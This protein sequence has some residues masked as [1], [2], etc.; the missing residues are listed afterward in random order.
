[1]RQ[2]ELR[3]TEK[4]PEGKIKA[5]IF[6]FDGTFSTLRCGWE[7]VMRPLMLEQISGGKAEDASEELKKEVD[8]YIDQS[9]GI[10]TVYQ[11][12]WL[13]EMVEAEGRGVEGRD[14]W[15]YKQQYNDRLM[16]QVSVRLDRLEKGLDDPSDYLIKGALDF[17]FELKKH[18]VE[19]YLASGTDHKDVMREAHA[20]GVD[21]YF[22]MIK[23][24]PEH[25]AAC[26]KEAVIRMILEEKNIKG[27]ELLLIGDGKVEIALGKEA[28]GFAIGAA[29]NEEALEGVNE[30][31]RQRLIKAG[32]DIITGDFTEL[33]A[34]MSWLGYED[35]FKKKTEEFTDSFFERHK[36]LTYLRGRIEK[37]ITLWRNTYRNG[38]KILLC[39]NGG[40]C[41]DAD[42]ITGELLKGFML[43]RPLD[44]KLKNKLSEYG[45]EGKDLADKLQQGL[46]AIALGNHSALISAFANDVDPEMVYAQQVLALGKKGDV[47]VGISTSGNAKNVNLAMK[48]AKALD[49]TTVGLTGKDGGKLKENSD[50]VLIAPEKETYLIQETHICIYH[51]LC[52]AVEYEMFEE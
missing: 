37:T 52:A 35:R 27:E 21:K 49:L 14:E 44:E 20:L 9:T 33:N 17:L 38:N 22:T 40:S 34:L 7:K 42:H 51:L 28:G 25:M 2:F 12:Q 26:S 6:D 31:K 5:A 19:T 4:F 47:L 23:G 10:Q 41:A 29:T 3:N 36:N 32:A 46:P 11:M 13:K 24:A 39:G 43:K 45:D 15:W 48:T 16:E 30:V 1:M 8:E 18:G 50:I